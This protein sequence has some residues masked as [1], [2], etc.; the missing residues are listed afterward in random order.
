MSSPKQLN[1][2]DLAYSRVLKI[3][4]IITVEK[5]LFNRFK[6]IFFLLGLEITGLWCL[7][8]YTFY[9]VFKY[10]LICFPFKFI[11]NLKSIWFYMPNIHFYIRHDIWYEYIRTTQKITSLFLSSRHLWLLKKIRLESQPHTR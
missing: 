5:L 4:L 10:I 2:R 6:I 3:A 9:Y 7:N 8:W 1:K 11:L